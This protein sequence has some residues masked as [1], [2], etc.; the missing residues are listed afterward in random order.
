M[1]HKIVLELTQLKVDCNTIASTH[2]CVTKIQHKFLTVFIR[3]EVLI[4]TGSR[5]CLKHF[6][7]SDRN[8]TFNNK[9]IETINHTYSYTELNASQVAALFNSLRQQALSSSIKARFSDLKLINKNECIQFLGSIIN[10]CP[11][12]SVL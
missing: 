6:E 5:S 11:F 2:I 10:G 8:N 3:S 4:P 12:I 1:L 7:N 9:A